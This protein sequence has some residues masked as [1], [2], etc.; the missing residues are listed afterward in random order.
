MAF[1]L[2]EAFYCCFMNLYP[3]ILIILAFYFI[4]TETKYFSFLYA[5]LSYNIYGLLSSIQYH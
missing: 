4:I 3:P 5:S 1:L 2:G